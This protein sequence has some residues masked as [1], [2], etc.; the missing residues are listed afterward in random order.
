MKSIQTPARLA[1][2]TI[3]SHRHV[4]AFFNSRDEEYSILLPF[5]KEGIER[6]ERALHVVASDSKNEHLSRL[7]R[8]GIAHEKA[9]RREQLIVFDWAETHTREGVLDQEAMLDRV[10]EALSRR[11]DASSR[12]RIL[13]HIEWPRGKRL[14]ELVDYD[15]RFNQRIARYN[16]TVVCVYDVLRFGAG[17]A[18]DI[19]RT[20]PMVIIGGVMHVN[21]FFLPPDDFLREMGERTRRAGTLV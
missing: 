12:T 18:M 6:G 10:E 14:D 16:G 3:G 2:T 21:P 19:L 8:A 9:V 15:N 11:H 17:V 13:A 7:S 5:I 1:G 20:H 4:C